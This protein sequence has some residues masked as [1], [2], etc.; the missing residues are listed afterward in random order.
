[1][2]FKR[3]KIPGFDKMTCEVYIIHSQLN[4][5]NMYEQALVELNKKDQLQNKEK[6]LKS[7]IKQTKKLFFKKK[8]TKIWNVHKIYYFKF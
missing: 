3:D 8:V 4:Y 2:H 5:G 6:Q 7:R 1:M